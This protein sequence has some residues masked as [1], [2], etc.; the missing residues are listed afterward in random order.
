MSER[1]WV[2]R[3]PVWPLVQC[4]PL[5]FVL[6]L[7]L[8]NPLTIGADCALNLQYGQ[9]L[10]EGKAPYVDFIDTNPP[11][12]MYLNA[13]PVL[14]ARVA[15]LPLVP[16]FNLLVWALTVASALGTRALLR[17]TADKNG[18]V[19]FEIGVLTF[20]FA[21]LALWRRLEFG[22]REHLFIL[23]YLP[24]L[25]ARLRRVHA[26]GL[27]AAAGL[28]VGFAAGVAACLKPHFVAMALAPEAYRAL[29]NHRWRELAA[30]ETGG[31][32]FAGAA[33]ALHF[34]F[35]PQA[36]QTGL[37]GRWAPLLAARY[38][39]FAFP[40]ATVLRHG[41][42]WPGAAACAIV[43]A[44]TIGRRGPTTDF[45]RSLG[46]AAF[47]GAIGY[48]L[49]RKGWAY[50]NIPAVV[51]GSCAVAAFLGMSIGARVVPWF[52]AARGVRPAAFAA[53]AA[54]NAVLLA[55]AAWPGP[56]ARGQLPQSPIAQI[57]E[58]DSPE[59]GA[60]V[61]IAT[62][63]EYQYPILTLL[64]RR[65]GSRYLWS[66]PIPMFR[67]RGQLDPDGAVPQRRDDLPAAE[68]RFLGELGDDILR[69]RPYLVF[70]ETDRYCLGCPQ[71]FSIPNY[72]AKVG[73]TETYLAPYRLL[74]V[75]DG[76]IVYARRGSG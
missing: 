46:V 8:R 37:F 55:A 16:V 25:A 9:L 5:A 47:V 42:V 15:S 48:L 22:Q 3:L 43:F 58:R 19:A 24:F 35:L 64:N 26:A 62:D 32:L 41:V 28:A 50:Q 36:V 57:I 56:A 17:P 65:P 29:R 7:I 21:S 75:L 70:V 63:V 51:A 11:L 76:L 31:F 61:F 6:C 12:I 49:Q 14:L 10:V 72:L 68:R 45:V 40:L 4:L 59:R 23:A 1:G 33:Y 44:L 39:A 53:A 67:C 60:V 38:D 66:F 74:A 69:N 52:A 71:G 18:A 54:L 20:S 30:P 34:L 2:A 73:F 27:P 13:A